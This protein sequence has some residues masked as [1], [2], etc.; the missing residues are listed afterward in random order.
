MNELLKMKEELTK[1]RDEKLAEI[2][3]YRDALAEAQGRSEQLETSHTEYNQRIQE[4]WSLVS[5]L[6]GY[7]IT[8]YYL[9]RKLFVL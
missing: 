7:S 8:N 1:D 9:V 4:V 6:P 3:K 5:S 2:V